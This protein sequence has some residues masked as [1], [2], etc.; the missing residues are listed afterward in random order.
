MIREMTLKVLDGEKAKKACYLDHYFEE[1]TYKD[2][3][4]GDIDVG[5]RIP[6]YTL[7]M[8]RLESTDDGRIEMYVDDIL[9]G[10]IDDATVEEL[11]TGTLK[12]GEA[13]IGSYKVFELDE[14]GEAKLRVYKYD[15]PFVALKLELP[16]K[17]TP[18]PRKKL[19]GI[20]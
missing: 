5:E 20:V 15:E 9:L 18:K 1:I 12:I 7:K 19:F 3:A 13:G 8:P 11:E 16:D 14:Y 10:Y 4:E 2:F 6:R 17:P